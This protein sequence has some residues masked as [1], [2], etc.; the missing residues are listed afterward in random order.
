MVALD[1]EEHQDDTFTFDA[2]VLV[3]TRSLQL[4]AGYP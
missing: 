4:A 1:E 3:Q 2:L